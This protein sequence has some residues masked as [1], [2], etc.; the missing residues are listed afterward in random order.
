MLVPR[1]IGNCLT[2]PDSGDHEQG[3]NLNNRDISGLDDHRSVLPIPSGQQWLLRG[4]RKRA[5]VLILTPP[6]C[7]EAIPQ[8]FPDSPMFLSINLWVKEKCKEIRVWVP[9]LG[10]SQLNYAPV[11]DNFP[12]FFRESP[13]GQHF[14]SLSLSHSISLPESWSLRF[15]RGAQVARLRIIVVKLRQWPEI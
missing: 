10:V 4:D 5:G 9:F 12:Q 15:P 11:A 8:P 7:W 1:D 6:S 14:V 3:S 2:N 13:M